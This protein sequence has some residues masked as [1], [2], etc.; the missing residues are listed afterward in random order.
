MYKRQKNNNTQY[1]LQYI[2]AK[3][4]SIISNYDKVMPHQARLSTDFLNKIVTSK[5]RKL[6][7]DI[8]ATLRPISTKFNTM[9]QNMAHGC[10]KFP[11]SKDGRQP[12]KIEKL[13]YVDS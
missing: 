2:Y 6:Y 13:Q 1:T 5:M 12:L 7:C 9:T 4:Y 11:N 8:S 10:L 3:L